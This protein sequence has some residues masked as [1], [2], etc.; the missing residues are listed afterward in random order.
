MTDQQHFNGLDDEQAA[1]VAARMFS[2]AFDDVHRLGCP[3][4][5][6]FAGIL[7]AAITQTLRVADP[8]PLAQW[9]RDVADDLEAEAESRGNRLQ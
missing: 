8:K 1:Q 2:R 3:L 4:N 5:V 9:M 7:R 6:C